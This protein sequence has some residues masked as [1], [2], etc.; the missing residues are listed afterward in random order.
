MAALRR[1]QE[2]KENEELRGYKVP[3]SKYEWEL[4]E[5][6]TMLYVPKYTA[7][8][9]DNEKEY[10][11]LLLEG[12]SIDSYMPIYEECK[13]YDSIVQ[14]DDIVNINGVVVMLFYEKGEKLGNPIDE[15]KLLEMFI[16]LNKI[17]LAGSKM[18]IY[19]YMHEIV[20]KDGRYQIYPSAIYEKQVDQEEYILLLQIYKIFEKF[21]LG[22][23]DEIEKIKLNIRER[24]V[25]VGKYE[26]HMKYLAEDNLNKALKALI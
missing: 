11:C 4:K 10:F 3:S 2:I 9:K 5:C 15:K 19:Y 24:E 22:F 7:K 12:D 18:M 26:E 17:N 1:V 25:K 6:E 14:F 21:N 23:K 13:K 8:R 20:F 16:E